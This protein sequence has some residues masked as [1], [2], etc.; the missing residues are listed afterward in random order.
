MTQSENR[1]CLSFLFPRPKKEDISIIDLESD[2]D[3]EIAFPYR[4]SDRFL[5]PSEYS[6]YMVAKKVLADR[7]ILCPQI[8]LS[9]IFFITD[10]EK[11]TSAF[12]RISRKRIDFLVCDGLTVKPLFGIELDD[13]S[14]QRNDRI[15]RDTFVEKVFESSGI[16]LL[17]IP[18]RNSYI[19]S[20][21][22]SIFAGVLRSIKWQPSQPG[23]N[24]SVSAHQN[25]IDVKETPPK[26]PKC[27]S[28]MFLRIAKSGSHAGENFYGCKNYPN[29]R[30]VI[31]V[32]PD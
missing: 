30:T 20:D 15:E 23:I 11:Y 27:G 31:P 3:D 12:N 14:H 7:F 25:P 32:K 26:C 1:G 22:E 17:R 18:L 28:D 6:F 21:L 5:S 4:A 13:K 8:P 16:P 2:T 24:N 29:C 10:K 19:T 9:A